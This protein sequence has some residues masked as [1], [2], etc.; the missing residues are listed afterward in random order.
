MASLTQWTRVWV[1]SGSWC[2][3]GGPGMLR[4]MKSQRV[5]HDWATELIWTELR[6]IANVHLFF[7]L[8]VIIHVSYKWAD[9]FLWWTQRCTGQ[10]PLQESGHYPAASRVGNGQLPDVVSLGPAS[11]LDP[12]SHFILGSLR[13]HV[14]EKVTQGLVQWDKSQH[15][16]PMGNL[17]SRASLWLGRDFVRLMAQSDECLCPLLLLPFIFP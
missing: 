3:T 8:T 13:Q 1:G 14:N 17:C 15:R 11:V 10:N 12:R 16:T 9:K 4:F 5:G 2:W 6:E 7:F